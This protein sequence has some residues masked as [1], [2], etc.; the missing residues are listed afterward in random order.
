MSIIVY[1]I[2]EDTAVCFL[3][4]SGS[5]K[6]HVS[7]YILSGFN[8]Y[9]W[10]KVFGTAALMGRYKMLKAEN[11]L[12]GFFQV[13]KVAASGIGFIS[14]HHTAPLLIAHGVCSRV[15]KKVDINIFRVNKEGVITGFLGNLCSLI[16]IDHLN[17]FYNLNSI[18]F[19]R[20]IFNIH[21]SPPSVSYT[22]NDMRENSP[23]TIT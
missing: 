9:S 8:C 4:V 21:K 15:G 6:V 14:Y 11:L 16:L 17:S 1:D 5:G 23:N 7:G 20:I 10:K 13:M 3:M 12:N 18:R 2:Y 19:C 22:E